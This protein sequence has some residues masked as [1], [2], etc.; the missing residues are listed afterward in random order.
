MSRPFSYNDENYTIIGNMLF[1]HINIG[2]KAYE[3][4]AI[5]AAIPPEILDRMVSYS[6][7]SYSS[8]KSFE[9]YG[10]HTYITVTKDGFFRNRATLPTTLE[11]KII[12]SYFFLKDI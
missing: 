11:D 2:K 4:N 5:I 3:E 12:Y 9:N 6:Q 8:I 1:L 10:M 7:Y